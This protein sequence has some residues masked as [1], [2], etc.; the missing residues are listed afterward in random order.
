MEDLV[1]RRRDR[2]HLAVGRDRVEG[3]PDPLRI[4]AV[5]LEFDIVGDAVKGVGAVGLVEPVRVGIAIVLAVDGNIRCEHQLIPG[6]RGTDI[7]RDHIGQRIRLDRRRGTLGDK[8]THGIADPGDGQRRAGADIEG[9]GRQNHR[10]PIRQQPAGT[11]R[12]GIGGKGGTGHGS[13]GDLLREGHEELRTR[14]ARLR[15]GD[16]GRGG[17][18]G[19]ADKNP[20]P[21]D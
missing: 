2:Q 10:L 17:V 18:G 19:I 11:D 12:K 1:R 5:V 20:H 4:T 15:R 16:R 13:G 6:R 8:V 3:G 14:R 7:R 9:R 21:P